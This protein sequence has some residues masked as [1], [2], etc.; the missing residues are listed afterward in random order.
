MLAPAPPQA[1]PS[2]AATPRPFDQDP[3]AVP[4]V[5]VGGNF[6]HDFSASALL[7]LPRVAANRGLFD[8]DWIM[9]IRYPRPGESESAPTP[10]VQIELMRWKRYEYRPELA[11]TWTDDQGRL[12][13]ADSNIFVDDATPHRFGIA[14][15]EDALTMS[16]DGKDVCRAKTSSFFSPGDRFYFQVG[17]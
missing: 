12:V 9:L 2:S 6:H 14:V 15:H 5:Y 4:Y 7:T 8:T 1:I 17:N 10:F 3:H 13:Y 16:L 11:Y